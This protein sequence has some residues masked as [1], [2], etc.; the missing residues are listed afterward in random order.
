MWNLNKQ[1]PFNIPF[2]YG[3]NK[4]Y[5]LLIITPQKKGKSHN[6]WF[7]NLI[8]KFLEIQVLYQNEGNLQQL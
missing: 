8:L 1:L 2:P 4:N 5:Y 3:Q 6:S 7:C